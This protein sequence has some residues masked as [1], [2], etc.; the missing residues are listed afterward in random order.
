[1]KR[2]QIKTRGFTLIELTVMLAIAGVLTATAVPSMRALLQNNSVAAEAHALVTTLY[3][4]RAE[5]IKR[6]TTVIVC[7]S[8]DTYQCVPAAH[9]SAWQNGWIVRTPHE[10]LLV[11]SAPPDPIAFS[12]D[13]PAEIRY[14]AS[15]VSTATANAALGLCARGGNQGRTIKLR[16]T[17]R[18]YGERLNCEAAA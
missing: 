13:A 16:A 14:E 18:P 6:G 4:A 12:R 2:A 1:M 15:G 10:V 8:R 17:G 9:G 5:A 3:F 11:H 7:P